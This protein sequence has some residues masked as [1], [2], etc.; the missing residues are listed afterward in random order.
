MNYTLGIGESAP[1]RRNILA[2]S[3]SVIYAGMP[4]ENRYSI[5]IAWTMGYQAT[6]YNLYF[7]EST[8]EISFRGGRLRFL[9]LSPERITFR[10]DR[11]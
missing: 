3:W 1:V 4:A 6:S 11:R 2:T 8:R 10:Y 5:V 9:E 7:T